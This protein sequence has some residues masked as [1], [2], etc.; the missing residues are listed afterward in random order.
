MAIPTSGSVSF[1][2]IRRELYSNVPSDVSLNDSYVR[3]L[4]NKPSG[5]IS[6]GDCRGESATPE[7]G[8]TYVWAQYQGKYAKNYTIKI[9]KSGYMTLRVRAKGYTYQQFNGPKVPSSTIAATNTAKWVRNGS[10]VLSVQSPGGYN[11]GS[12][13]S[14]NIYVSVNEVFYTSQR[15]EQ[16]N[17]NQDS[18]GEYNIIMATGSDLSNFNVVD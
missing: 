2:T 10:T 9:L 14:A 15:D 3:K 12:L 6:F 18:K 1:D 17:N 4:P 8:T 11:W 16:G 5:Q 13:V 7:S